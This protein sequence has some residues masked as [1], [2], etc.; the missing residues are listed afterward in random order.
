MYNGEYQTKR[1]PNFKTKSPNKTANKSLR[2][3]S[4]RAGPVNQKWQAKQGPQ[5]I[6]KTMKTKKIQPWINA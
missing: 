2:V 4:Q 6:H 3:F 1:N 5:I